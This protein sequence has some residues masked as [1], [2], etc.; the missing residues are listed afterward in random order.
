LKG[1]RLL[2]IEA[3]HADV[4][5]DIFYNSKKPVIGYETDNSVPP[6]GTVATTALR[7][8]AR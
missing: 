7:K 2:T 4:D 6:P 5:V 3:M 1:W 8:L